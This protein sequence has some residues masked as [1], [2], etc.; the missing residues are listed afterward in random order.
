MQAEFFILIKKYFFRI[1]DYKRFCN[2]MLEI[3]DFKI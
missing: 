3:A 2:Y 1:Y